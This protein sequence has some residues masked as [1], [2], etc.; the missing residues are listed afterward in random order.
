LSAAATVSATPKQSVEA[1]VL[2]NVTDKAT[3]STLQQN[4][5]DHKAINTNSGDMPDLLSDSVSSDSSEEAELAARPSSQTHITVQSLPTALHQ[6]PA[7]TAGLIVL[8]SVVVPG[9]PSS[10]FDN[11]EHLQLFLKSPEDPAPQAPLDSATALRNNP[12]PAAQVLTTNDHPSASPPSSCSPTLPNR[13]PGH[14]AP[15][16]KEDGQ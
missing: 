8:E 6:K 1:A 12:A 2:Q 7:S 15:M 9:T 11:D 3:V 5:V 14:S 16:R 10:I 13:T 4:N